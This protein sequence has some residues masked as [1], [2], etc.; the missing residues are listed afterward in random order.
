MKK[1]LGVPSLVIALVLSMVILPANAIA[2]FSDVSPSAWYANDVESVQQY[3][4]INGTGNGRFSPNG[5]LTLAEAITMAARTYAHINCESIPSTTDSTWYAPYLRYANEKGICSM[6]EFG[7][8]YN[9]NCNRLTMAKL[10][11]RVI[12][13]G[14]DTTINNVSSLPD[15]QRND[16]NLPVFH[17]YQLGVLTGSDKYGTF[18]PYQSITRAETAAILHRVLEPA[19]RKTIVLAEIPDIDSLYEEAIDDA[20]Y[21]FYYN[22]E[23]T[24]HYITSEMFD[25]GD[26][27]YYLDDIDGNGIDEVLLVFEYWPEQIYAIYTI[28]NY[29]VECLGKGYITDRYDQYYTLCQ[30]GRIARWSFGVGYEAM[31]LY[32]FPQNGSALKLTDSFI[33]EYNWYGND[34]YWYSNKKS[35]DSFDFDTHAG[36]QAISPTYYNSV[37]ESIS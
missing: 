12:P 6:G 8:N 9:G 27:Y 24:A 4:I 36:Y 23:M 2:A 32:Q 26:L 21:E 29:Q 10:F 30:D 14:T 19:A 37:L 11:E 3:G 7:A 28:H 33:C 15:V 31:E 1:I 22:D 35:L 25:G 13:R 18:N 16:S 34:S 5:N 17:L 20:C